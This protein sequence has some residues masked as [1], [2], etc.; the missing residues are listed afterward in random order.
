[1]DHTF[2]SIKLYIKI[3]FWVCF[4]KTGK[5]VEFK[6]FYPLGYT[7]FTTD[8]KGTSCDIIKLKKKKSIFDENMR[9]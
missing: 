5:Y 2:H 6:H 9:E 8:Q 1:M 3:T 7:R 4:Q